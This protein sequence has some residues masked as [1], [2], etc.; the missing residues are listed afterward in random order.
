MGAVGDWSFQCSSSTRK[1]TVWYLSKK[2][3]S[4]SVLQTQHCSCILL[5]EQS[6]AIDLSVGCLIEMEQ[7]LQYNT[8]DHMVSTYKLQLSNKRFRGTNISWKNSR[9]TV[10]EAI[11]TCRPYLQSV[12]T[13]SLCQARMHYWSCQ[14]WSP[15][16]TVERLQAGTRLL[17][18]HIS[19][20]NDCLANVDTYHWHWQ[21]LYHDQS[22][23]RKHSEGHI[24]RYTNQSF[25]L[26]ILDI[27]L[28]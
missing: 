27:S 12:P 1:R 24:D 23:P 11:S 17:E 28:W 7:S 3:S 10:W 8:N 20:S 16:W 25:G 18:H 26:P 19:T 4:L 2:S 9:W 14:R 13:Y 5:N 15:L 21:C 22:S 6:S